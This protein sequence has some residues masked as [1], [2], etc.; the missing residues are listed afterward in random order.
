MLR[1]TLFLKSGNTWETTVLGSFYLFANK[2]RALSCDSKT[3]VVHVLIMVRSN[4]TPLL[5][6][7]R[8]ERTEISVMHFKG[9]VI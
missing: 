4:R 5:I 7:G 1:I 9:K 2:V 8:L 3:G 6:Q